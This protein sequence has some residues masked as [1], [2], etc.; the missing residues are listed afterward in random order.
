[1]QQ[2][3]SVYVKTC[4]VITGDLVID[5]YLWLFKRLMNFNVWMIPIMYIIWPKEKSD[6]VE[7]I[8]TEEAT[9]FGYGFNSFMKSRT[10][11]ATS[12][13]QFEDNLM[14]S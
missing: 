14:M 4:N 1:L 13:G 8:S 2:I 5:E 10:S 11:G 7:I 3:D 12:V 6:A 9:G